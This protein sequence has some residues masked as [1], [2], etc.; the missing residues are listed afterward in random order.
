MGRKAIINEGN[1]EQFLEDYQ[2][3][4]TVKA[5]AAKWAMHP[6]TASSSLRRLGVDTN[7]RQDCSRGEY[8]PKLGIWS[9]RRVAE[10]LGVSHQ[11]VARA[12][13]RRGIEPGFLRAMRIV[14]A[15]EGEANE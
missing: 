11:A 9:D 10:A 1:Q 4:G 5:L 8:H 13:G 3:L 15:G 2:V 12:R 7:K 6:V 14:L